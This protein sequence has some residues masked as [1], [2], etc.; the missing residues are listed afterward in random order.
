MIQVR[1]LELIFHYRLRLSK[2][3]TNVRL[4]KSGSGR[5]GSVSTLVFRGAGSEPSSERF[6]AASLALT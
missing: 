4:S 6:P 5:G 2:A 3:L 1:D